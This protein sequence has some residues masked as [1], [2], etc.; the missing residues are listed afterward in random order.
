MMT[1]IMYTLSKMRM[2]L[3]ENAQCEL[4]YHIYNSTLFKLFQCKTVSLVIN[5]IPHFTLRVF[6]TY[7][8]IL[9]KVQALISEII[10]HSHETDAGIRQRNPSPCARLHLLGPVKWADLALSFVTHRHTAHFSQLHCA[11]R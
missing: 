3:G 5:M 9:H 6:P 10:Q 8:L 1:T 2:E 11:C 4:W 7:I